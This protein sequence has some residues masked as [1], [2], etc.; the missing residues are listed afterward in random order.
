MK[1]F[2]FS[3]NTVLSYKQ[4]VLDALQGEHAAIIAEVHQQE[5]RLQQLQQEYN[6]FAESYRT[7]CRE[8]MEIREAMG[9]QAKLRARER[10]ME[11]Q[12]AV[13]QQVRKR[14]EEKR[15]QVVEAKKDTSSL[16]KLQE[17]KRNAYNTAIAKSEE[18]FIEEFVS[19]R[20][21]DPNE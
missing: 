6:A 8:G 10:E 9:H 5:L 14:E 7:R 21:A 12:A 18:Q 15:M 16:E 2:K 4:Q 13:L 1:K 20:R 17:K 19:S 11:Q 3:L